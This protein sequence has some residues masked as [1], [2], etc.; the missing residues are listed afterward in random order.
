MDSKK[1]FGEM[2][3]SAR[4]SRKITQEKFAKTIGISTLYCRMLEQGKYNPTWVLW[5]KICA[6]LD[7]DVKKLRD[8]CVIPELLETAE[9]LGYEINF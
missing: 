6:E 4:I 2:M 3:R 9:I 8:I 1:V 5:L 7:I